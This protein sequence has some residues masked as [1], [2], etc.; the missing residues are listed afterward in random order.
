ML[1]GTARVGTVAGEVTGCAADLLVPKWFS[2]DPGTSHDEDRR[3]LANGARDAARLIAERGEGTVFDHWRAAQEALVEGRPEPLV[4]MFGVALV[5]RALIDAVCRAAGHSF[6]EA[7]REDLLGLRFGELDPALDGW[8]PA[9]LGARRESV[10]L[11]H[12]VGLADDLEDADLGPD[13]ERTGGHPITLAE[14]VERYD[15]LF[16]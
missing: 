12:T 14:D 2:K 1:R 10:R 16:G 7:L 9:S 11:R 13:A 5:E 4:P 3:A 8:R 6:A 15:N